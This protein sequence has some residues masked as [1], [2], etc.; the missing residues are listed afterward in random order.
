ML[1]GIPVTAMG[2]N[3]WSMGNAP[4]QYV[5]YGLQHIHGRTV[6][7]NAESWLVKTMNQK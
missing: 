5:P 4:V 6:T 2:Q 3:D 1:V 7:I